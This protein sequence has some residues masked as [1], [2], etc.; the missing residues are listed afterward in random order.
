MAVRTCFALFDAQRE[1]HG[2]R[3]PTVTEAGTTCT[4]NAWNAILSDLACAQGRG[5]HEHYTIFS[6]LH[7]LQ[8]SAAHMRSIISCLGKP[9][10]Q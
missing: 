2:A 4:K 9:H 8:Q 1:L 3:A 10:R 5:G 7:R 6:H